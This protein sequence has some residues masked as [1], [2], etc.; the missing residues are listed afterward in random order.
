MEIKVVNLGAFSVRIIKKAIKLPK[1]K[2]MRKCSILGL[3][4]ITFHGLAVACCRR[5]KKK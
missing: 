4:L 2:N 3:L 1:I 5:S